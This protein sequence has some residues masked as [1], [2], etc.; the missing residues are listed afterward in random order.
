MI[1]EIPDLQ[2]EILSQQAIVEGGLDKSLVKLFHSMSGFDLLFKMLTN[3]SFADRSIITLTIRI[4]LHV[5]NYLT[6]ENKK[7]FGL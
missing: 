3:R 2:L 7:A 5:I 6:I 4:L 1:V